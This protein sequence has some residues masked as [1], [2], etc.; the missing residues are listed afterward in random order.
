MKNKTTYELQERVACLHQIF[1][2]LNDYAHVFSEDERFYKQI[3]RL[4]DKHTE[5][6]ERR[7]VEL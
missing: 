5:E 6:I 2:R 1:H 3:E 4:I 7:E